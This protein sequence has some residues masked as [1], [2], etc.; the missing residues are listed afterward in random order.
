ML[1]E[2]PQIASTECHLIK[3]A[4]LYQMRNNAGPSPWFQESEE[5]KYEIQL[6]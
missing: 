3:A 2:K 5:E 1:P 6:F 4:P